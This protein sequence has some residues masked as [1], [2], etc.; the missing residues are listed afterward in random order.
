M[1]VRPIEHGDMEAGVEMAREDAKTRPTLK[2]NELRTRATIAKSILTGRPTIFVAEGADGLAGFL[3]ADYA[4]YRGF[5]GLFTIQ[6]V[7]FVRPEK[8]GSRAAAL[9]MAA[10]VAWSR[11]I[12]AT[13]IIGGNDNETTSERTAAFL[14]RFGFRKV[15]YA[16]RKDLRDGQ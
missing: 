15:G 8:R 11:K 9:L 13:E 10:F 16:M 6:E 14:S 3:V 1:K 7:L 4:P 12:G 5:D 2:F